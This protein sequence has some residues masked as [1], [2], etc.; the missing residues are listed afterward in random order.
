[1]T[2]DRLEGLYSR[3]G[4]L[5]YARCKR[6]LRDAALAEDATQ[7]VF[8]KLAPMLTPIFKDVSK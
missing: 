2:D 7:E 3:L 5:L 6:V 4:P 8:M 1:M